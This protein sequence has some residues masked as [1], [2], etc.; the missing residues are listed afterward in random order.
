VTKRRWKRVR[1]RALPLVAAGLLG[2]LA[3]CL[4][5]APAE[6]Q[7]GQLIKLVYVHGALV[8]VGL[9]AFSVAGGLGLVAL[10]VRR[11]VWY[12]GTWA[13]G[14]AA[15]IVWII[16]ILSSMAVTG[17]AWGQVIAWNEPRVRASALILLAAVVLAV[18][19]RLVGERDFTAAVNLV[20]GILPWVLV[21]RAE[22]IR[23]P[24][25]PIGSSQ[26]AN[27]QG[28][29]VLI[30]LAVAGLALALIAWLWLGA[31]LREER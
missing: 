28:F 27:I 12:N 31:E 22:A 21:R 10:V 25:D 4:I 29:F 7:L 26:S 13:A 5:L 2:S 30:V 8:M 24:L 3:V 23:H 17:L 14:L 11:R 1:D 16:Y 19:T 6:A 20:M 18:V 9:A 15:L